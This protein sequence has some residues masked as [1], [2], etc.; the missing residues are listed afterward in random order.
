MA[1]S[2]PN[3]VNV[4]QIATFIPA[5]AVSLRLLSAAENHA[6][7]LP[8]DEANVSTVTNLI[9]SQGKAPN[10]VYPV[11]T[12]IRATVFWI[13]EP[14]GNGSSENNAVSAYDDAWQEHYGG[15]DDYNSQRR[16]PTYC[17]GLG[18]RPKQNPF[19]LDLP[20]DD[21]NNAK[22][23]VRRERVVPWAADYRRELAGPAPFSLM[24][25]R[26]V[27]IWRQVG[28]TTYTAYGQIADAGPYAYDD[29]AYVFGT[30]DERPRSRRAKNAGMDVSPALRDYLHF[31][32]INNAD[33]QV[34]WQFVEREDV[35]TG[36]WTEIET[37]QQVYQP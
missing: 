5:L 35:P 3:Q 28:D 9:S 11:H 34:G 26:W 13:G 33:N 29:A 17:D 21:I 2:Q 12:R 1:L 8:V 6:A 30:H 24:K 31:D 37:T 18:F 27:K 25:N 32:G 15:Y 36:P 22:A 7:G 23:K 16:A 19:Y 10:R 14:K 4:K 20:F